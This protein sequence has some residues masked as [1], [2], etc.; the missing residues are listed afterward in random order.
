MQNAFVESLTQGRQATN[1]QLFLSHSLPVPVSPPACPG[2]FSISW[3]F[4]FHF[5]KL[6]SQIP[7]LDLYQIVF[8]LARLREAFPERKQFPIQVC[9]L[10][11]LCTAMSGR[12]HVLFIGSLVL[13]T[14]PI[15]FM[16]HYG[17]HS[18]T[19]FLEQYLIFLTPKHKGPSLTLCVDANEV[20]ALLPL[21][22]LFFIKILFIYERHRERGRERSRVHAGS[23]MWNQILGLQDHT[24]SQR[25]IFN[26]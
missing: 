2:S 17:I 1:G 6:G 12:A 15:H 3:I 10:K 14:Q 9:V 16:V 26:H 4:F 21:L 24:L 8:S 11:S 18:P 19:C 25:Q 20:L 13:P 23:P 7:G 22:Q 5:A